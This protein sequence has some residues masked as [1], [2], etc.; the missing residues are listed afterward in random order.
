M[1]LFKLSSQLRLHWI[2]CVVASRLLCLWE[3]EQQIFCWKRPNPQISFQLK[4]PEIL[5][6]FSGIHAFYWE[7]KCNGPFDRRRQNLSLKTDCKG[8]S[9]SGSMEMADLLSCYAEEYALLPAPA[10]NKRWVIVAQSGHWDAQ[11]VCK[12]RFSLLWRMLL[13]TQGSFFSRRKLLLIGTIWHTQAHWQS[14]A[15]G[16]WTRIGFFLVQDLFP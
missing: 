8:R 4:L 9:P 3:E 16:G 2:L 14:L 11:I 6:S 12:T 15:E 1:K 7:G 13:H 5:L 10:P